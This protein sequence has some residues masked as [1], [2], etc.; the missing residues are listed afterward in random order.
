VTQRPVT[1]LS[2]P[3]ASA[4]AGPAWFAA[5]VEQAAIAHPGAQFTA[6]LDCGALPGDALAALRHGLKAIRYDGPQWR[7][8]Q[9]IAAQSGACVMKRRPRSLDLMTLT[10]DDDAIID[11]CR[12][13][14]SAEKAAP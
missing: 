11:A 1:V 7:K 9:N 4:A 8:I 5:V 13:W 3:V 10:G 14:L 6:V 12:Q 2:A